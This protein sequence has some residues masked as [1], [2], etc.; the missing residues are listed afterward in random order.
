MTNIKVGTFQGSYPVSALKFST[1]NRD[2]VKNHASN[3]IK[4][5]EDRQDYKIGCIEEIAFNN[6]WIGKKQ[7]I[8]RIKFCAKTDYSKYLKSLI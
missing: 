1:V 7:I 6:K 3:F 4:N 5:I 8:N 2:I